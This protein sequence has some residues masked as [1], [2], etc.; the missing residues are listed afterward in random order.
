MTWNLLRAQHVVAKISYVPLYQPLGFRTL[1]QFRDY[2][3]LSEGMGSVSFPQL[4][5]PPGSGERSIVG[6]MVVERWADPVRV[7]QI[8]D[9]RG[10]LFPLV[11]Q[12][13]GTVVCDDEALYSNSPKF[14]TEGT[15]R[16]DPAAIGEVRPTDVVTLSLEQVALHGGVVPTATSLVP[17]GL[18]AMWSFAEIVCRGCQV[19]LDLQSDELQA[20][21][22]PVRVGDFETRRVFL[23]DRL[24]NGAGYAPE[25]AQEANLKEVL[26][27][28]LG[29]LAELL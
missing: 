18:S 6:A 21:L 1:Y 26:S 17:A 28:I 15:S 4:A 9:N 25:L 11:R 7:I 2:D 16:I 19:A 29:E 27:G 24:E 8:N 22:Q 13:D 20:G 23:A 3:D 12:R 14:D 10:S 5:I